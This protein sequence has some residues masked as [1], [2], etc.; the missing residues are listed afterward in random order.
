MKIIN[1][2]DKTTGRNHVCCLHLGI[3][4]INVKRGDHG[5][6][7]CQNPFTIIA[8][9]FDMHGISVFLTKIPVDVNNPLNIQFF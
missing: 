4:D 7:F 9:N 5:A 1:V 8:Y 6:D 3:A 2:N